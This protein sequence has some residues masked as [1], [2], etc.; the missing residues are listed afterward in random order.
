MFLS[1]NRIKSIYQPF[2]ACGAIRLIA[3]NINKIQLFVIH[4]EN[5]ARKFHYLK[6]NETNTPKEVTDHEKDIR[7]DDGSGGGG[8][9][10]G[11]FRL[12]RIRGS[13]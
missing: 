4:P 8:S 3:N 1:I 11:N 13:G 12:C 10:D 2:A 5:L 9:S 7:N 6:T